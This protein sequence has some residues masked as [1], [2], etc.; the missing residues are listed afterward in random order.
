[1]NKY[2]AISN[3]IIRL[4]P[5]PLV[6]LKLKPLIDDKD[7]VP[8]RPINPYIAADYNSKKAAWVK[9]S[10]SKSTYFLI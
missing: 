1:V 9:P 2:L 10:I 6:I 5:L 7:A 4:N 3:K 8:G